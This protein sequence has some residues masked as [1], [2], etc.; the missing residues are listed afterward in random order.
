MFN[1]SGWFT[2]ARPPQDDEATARAE[3]A[4]LD[5]HARLRRQ[6]GR[7]RDDKPRNVRV[8]ERNLERRGERAVARLVYTAKL[9]VTPAEFRSGNIEPQRPVTCHVLDSAVDIDRCLDE[10]VRAIALAMHVVESDSSLMPFSIIWR[11]TGA[12]KDAFV[13]SAGKKWQ[14]MQE[15]GVGATTA[16]NANGGGVRRLVCGRSILSRPSAVE[17]F[18]INTT[19]EAFEAVGF[20]RTQLMQN[21]AVLTRSGLYRIPISY[22]Y[23][24]LLRNVHSACVLADQRAH[25]APLQVATAPISDYQVLEDGTDFLIHG[26]DLERA[27]AYIEKTLQPSNRAFALASP[28]VTVEPF[29]GGKWTE[30]WQNAMLRDANAASVSGAIT[31]AA[32]R[33]PNAEASI[34][35]VA[36]VGLIPPNGCE[37]G[38]AMPAFASTQMSR[39][40]GA[41]ASS[42]QMP[43]RSYEIRQLAHNDGALELAGAS[44]SEDDDDGSDMILATA[45]VLPVQKSAASTMD[46]STQSLTT[47][48]TTTT[49]KTPDEEAK[50]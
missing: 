46:L 15:R 40:D 38:F 16:S 22:T 41:A 27:I 4:S 13:A 26:T 1:W 37:N 34:T 50:K 24:G 6:L 43:T 31:S 8:L 28:V 33:P 48:T 7:I 25:L 14:A 5:E 29:G 23:S 12:E 3:E 30:A 11:S 2:H 42:S 17:E 39:D 19:F 10:G 32:A 18:A 36:Y 49:S 44:N 9:E 45:A 21:V 20:D 47:T 35:I